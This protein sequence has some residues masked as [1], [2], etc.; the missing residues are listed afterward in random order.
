MD[1]GEMLMN[2]VPTAEERELP[3]PRDTCSPEYRAV[4]DRIVKGAEFISTLSPTDADYERAMR[5]YDKLCAEA[6]RLRDT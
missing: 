1:L 3:E 4:L 5:K 2:S 6:E